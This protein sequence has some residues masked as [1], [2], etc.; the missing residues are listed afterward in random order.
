MYRI[1]ACLDMIDG[2]VVKGKKFEEKPYNV[3]LSAS[4]GSF[5]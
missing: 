4:K 5:L 1:I 2:K 3:I